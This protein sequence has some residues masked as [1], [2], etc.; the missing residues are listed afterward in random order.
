MKM[1]LNRLSTAIKKSKVTY[2]FIPTIL[3]AFFFFSLTIQNVHLQTYEIERFDRAKESIRSPITIENKQETERKTHE[4]VQAVS[5]RYTIIED[6]K[7]ERLNYADELFDAIDTLVVE[8]DKEDKDKNEDVLSNEELVFQLQQI[9]SEDII[10]G[11]NQMTLIQLIQLDEEVRKKSR[12]TIKT[13][14]EKELD[15]GVR[16]ENIQTAK[17]EAKA[18]VRLS[19]FPNELKEA[20]AKLIDFL[21][22]ENSFFD[23]EKT[24]Q[25][26][27]EAASNVDP[28]MIRAGDILVNEG[29]IITNEIYEELKLV[30]LLKQQKNIKPAIGLALFVLLLAA[31][32]VNELL[33]LYRRGRLNFGMTIIM[34]TVSIIVVSIMKTFSLFSNQLEYIYMAAPVAVGVLLIKVLIYERFSIVSAIIYSLLAMIIFN[35]ELPGV[36]NIEAGLY[37]LLFQ[38]AAI[39]FLRN[40]KDRMT[41]IRSTIGMALMNSLSIIIFIL[42]SFISYDSKSLILY[43]LMAITAAILSAVLTVGLLPFFETGL[44]ILSDNQLLTLANP[45][46]PLLK[47]LLTEAPGSYHH[48]IMVANLSETAC[49]A[50][51]ANGLLARV[52]SYYHDIGKTVQPHYFIENQLS[53]RNPHDFLPPEESA[54]IIISHVTEGV[55]MLQKEQLPKE[56]IDI[57]MQH[58]GTS[59]VE[60]FYYQAKKVNPDME[61]DLFRYPGPIPQTKETAVISICDSVEAAVRSLKEPSPEKIDEIVQAIIQKRLLDGQFDDSPLTMCDLQV[62][63]E[64]IGET[65]KGIF[66]SRIQYPSEG[67]K[68][69]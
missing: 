4:S 7:T 31:A 12:D 5:D 54:K 2:V 35:G 6:I 40:L 33:R 56:I 16:M 61:E 8:N 43:F 9:L 62:V 42:L 23:M 37:Y 46:Q 26:R 47:K 51:G 14:V 39:F 49:E 66:H 36:L 48:S 24:M 50:I 29:Q 22:V 59:L 58:H 64:T 34:F 60:Y 20:F 11:V 25:A 68:K 13:V 15:K 52:G 63:R 44:G 18:T 69:A 27:N 1:K 38:F 65:L 55:K 28:V 57:A 19:K 53:M 3:L 30:G 67:E 21:I 41:L 32:M 45:N 17:E 10:N